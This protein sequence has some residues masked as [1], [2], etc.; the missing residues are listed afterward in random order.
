M[1]PDRG[2]R[3]RWG[4]IV[5]LV[6]YIAVVGFAIFAQP[7]YRSPIAK[8]GHAVQAKPDRKAED[9]HPP[10][11]PIATLKAFRAAED[12]GAADCGAS[13]ECRSE[14]RNYSDLQAQW[15]AANAAEGQ[16]TLATWQTILAALG[17]GL[18]VWT[19]Y[20]SRKANTIAHN[21]Y[22]SDQRPWLYSTNVIVD[23]I[24]D[25]VTKS[26]QG[27]RFTL[28]WIN[29]GK[30]P[31]VDCEMWDL[32]FV[33]LPDIQPED[34]RYP[35]KPASIPKSIIGPNKRFHSTPRAIGMKVV[36]DIC[37]GKANLF[38]YGR[39]D[40]QSALYSGSPLHTEV[41]VRVIITSHPS[42]IHSPN[43]DGVDVLLPNVGP[44]NTCR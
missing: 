44:R 1:V 18:L 31:A 12:A 7:E 41:C 16:K 24:Q 43:V 39:V 22:I 8:P 35:G 2:I 38:L 21:A 42:V 27:V 28:D 6:G 25:P 4:V 37:A 19:L 32:A 36:E 3:S 26:V 9:D 15:Q 33:E 14:Q 30:S 5:A 40:Y 34:L 17:T 11:Y 20:E 10:P 23:K 29:G 13:E